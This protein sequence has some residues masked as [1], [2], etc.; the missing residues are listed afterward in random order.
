MTP[1]LYLALG[2][3]NGFAVGMLVIGMAVM[4]RDSGRG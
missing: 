4:F 1:L 3:I 2:F